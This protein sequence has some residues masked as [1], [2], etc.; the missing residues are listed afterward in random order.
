ML[1]S[2]QIVGQV[3]KHIV[4]R[5]PLCVC[6]FSERALQTDRGLLSEPGAAELGQME[7]Q[8]LRFFTLL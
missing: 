3:D 1:V 8:L 6:L 5:R 4:K 2:V 7:Y